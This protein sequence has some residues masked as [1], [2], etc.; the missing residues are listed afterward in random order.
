MAFG[1]L[2]AALVLAGWAGS[3]AAEATAVPGSARPVVMARARH[4]PSPHLQASLGLEGSDSVAVELFVRNRGGGRVLLRR[5]EIKLVTA[6]G[7]ELLPL[8][9]STD[10]GQRRSRRISHGAVLASLPLLMVG[11][12]TSAVTRAEEDADLRRAPEGRPTWEDAVLCEACSVAG[13]VRFEAPRVEVSGADLALALTWIDLEGQTKS[14]I[15][16][17]LAPIGLAGAGA[18]RRER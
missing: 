5:S 7:T 15:R 3:A 16:L 8:R 17:P 6:D 13:V 12:L 9:P 18:G 14:T 4:L 1:A 11:L 2:A 10:P